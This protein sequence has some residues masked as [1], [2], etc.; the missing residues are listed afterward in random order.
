MKP[1]HYAAACEKVGNLKLL[2]AKG[3]NFNDVDLN[4]HTPAHI[5]AKSGRGENLKYILEQAPN[6]L[7]LRTKQSL[8]AMAFACERSSLECI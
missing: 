3:A 1:I 2:Q 7:T 8:T 6:L 4:K 5:A